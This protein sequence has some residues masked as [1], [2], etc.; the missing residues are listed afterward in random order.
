MH[1]IIIGALTLLVLT[2]ARK[3]VGVIGDLIWNELGEVEKIIWTHY[4]SRAS[5]KGHNPHTP[6]ECN[7]D[8]CAKI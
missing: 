3:A 1:D 5:N 8:G 4:F 2:I 6:K 7:Q